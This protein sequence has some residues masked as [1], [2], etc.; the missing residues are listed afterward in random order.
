MCE[1]DENGD[2]GGVRSDND[3][4]RNTSYDCDDRDSRDGD[5][6]NSDGGNVCGGGG[7]RCYWWW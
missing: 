3:N 6:S 5:N 7:D 1:G 2:V 4:A